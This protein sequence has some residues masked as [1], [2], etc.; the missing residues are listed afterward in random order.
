MLLTLGVS[1][2]ICAQ[3]APASANRIEPEQAMYRLLMSEI[4]VQRGEHAQA[5][6][7]L[8]DLAKVTRD[9]RVARRAV[10]MAFQ[11]NESESA[12]DASLLWLELD[13]EA[14]LPKQALAGAIGIHGNGDTV[15]ANLTK[16]FGVVGRAPALFMHVNGLLARLSDKAATVSFVQE[17]ARVH[18]KLPEAHYAIAFAHL[19]ADDLSRA[20]ESADRALA[21]RKDWDQGA[22]LKSR[23]L[24]AQPGPDA[25]DKAADYMAGF[26]KAHPGSVDARLQYARLL[27]SQNALLSARE[28]F[29]AIARLDPQ[30]AEHAHAIALMSQQIEDWADAE[31]QLKRALEL[32]PKDANAVRYSLGT[33]AAAQQKHDMAIEWFRQVGTGE[34]F[35]NAQLRIANALVKRDGLAAGRKFLSEA[36]RADFDDPATKTQLVLAEA[37][38][39][40]DAKLNSE[41]FD[42]LT[43]A[44][45]QLPDSPDLLYDRAMVAEKLNRLEAMEIDLRRVIELKPE[46][47]HALNALGYTFAE[48]NIRLDEA[49]QLVKKA[50]E[51]EPNDAFILDSLG[52]VHFRRGQHDDALATLKKAYDMRRDAEIAAHL[53]EVMLA[54]GQR[55]EAQ[56][57]L[58]AAL[59]E[60]PG[61][62]SLLAMQKKAMP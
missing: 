52:W 59:V 3:R 61:H 1:G 22:I 58:R 56:V 16:A 42:F 18:A 35:V 20:A 28:Q 41:A 55:E 6:R 25:L 45:A 50:I 27:F 37:Q 11:V 19:A 38:L 53:A 46:H 26:V 2:D 13:H 32:G 24:R 48:R 17:L 62:E 33:V 10:E 8:M 31:A 43:A 57:L 54:K 14:S 4:A 23:I 12:I 9:A 30:N 21:L 40:R 29:R 39:L 47:A 5:L 36:Q 7:T 49:E 44:V 60:H 15:K 34:Y 51:L